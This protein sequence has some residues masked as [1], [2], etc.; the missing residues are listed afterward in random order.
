MSE[1]ITRG[2][3]KRS[4]IRGSWEEKSPFFHHYFILV[5]L[6]FLEGNK[7]RDDNGQELNF[8]CS[9]GQF[10]FARLSLVRCIET[11]L[12]LCAWYENFIF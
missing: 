8:E 3:W 7:T 12:F 2:K 4:H 10:L 6:V 11:C 9:V 5:P 1:I